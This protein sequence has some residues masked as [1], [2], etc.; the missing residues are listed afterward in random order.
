MGI[1]SRNLAGLG[2]VTATIKP[3][4]LAEAERLLAGISGGFKVAARRAIARTL[5]AG[6]TDISKVVRQEITLAKKDVDKRLNVT[7]KP[8]FGSNWGIG[9][10]TVSRKAVPLVL[11]IRGNPLGAQRSKGASVKVRKADRRQVLKS[12]WVHVSRRGNTNVVERKLRG[13]FFGRGRR[14][15]RLP[16]EPRY[17]PTVHGVFENNPLGNRAVRDLQKFLNKRVDHEVRYMIAMQAKRAN[18]QTASVPPPLSP[19]SDA[20]A[21]SG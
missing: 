20:P 10:L 8:G 5:K 16:I 17:G 2:Q 1:F 15:G 11:Y 14:V 7:R 19:E 9:V 18:A 12:T 6:R 13:G 4:Q 3:K 21:S